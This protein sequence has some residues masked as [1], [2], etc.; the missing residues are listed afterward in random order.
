MR[1]LKRFGA[2]LL[3]L[4]LSLSLAVP[5]FAAVEDTG[6][7]D[8]DADAWYAEAV[9]YCRA[10]GLMDGVGGGRF[11]PD[12]NL[13]RAQLA[14]VLYRMEGEPPV[15]GEDGFTDTDS[16]IWYSNAVLWASQQKLMEGYGGGI[17]GTDDPVTRQDMTAVLYRNADSPEANHESRYEDESAIA[18]YASA[19]VDWGT[20][21]NIVRP[22]SEGVFAPRSNAARAQV[23]DALMNYHR[24]TASTPE[25][26]TRAT[27][28]PCR[29][30]R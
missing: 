11:D 26:P 15:T 2:L 24:M 8:V 7:S 17:F 18:D 9:I 27:T 19:A 20:A 16:G 22:A 23:A 6:Y 14:T 3:T 13:T 25:Q 30:K 28:L 10:H 4:V 1:N 5:A 21:N 29:S 12:G